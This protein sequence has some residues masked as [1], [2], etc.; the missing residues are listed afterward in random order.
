MT[1]FVLVFVSHS[2]GGHHVWQEC[3]QVST[4]A[5]KYMLTFPKDRYRQFS[6][7]L[8]KIREKCDEEVDFQHGYDS[9]L[10]EFYA[11]PDVVEQ[12]M[13]QNHTV[14]QFYDVLKTLAPRYMDLVNKYY[15]LNIEQEQVDDRWKSDP[16]YWTDPLVTPLPNVTKLKIYCSMIQR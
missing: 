7:K 12:I 9:I 8:K 13:T 4:E 3:S 15:H 14:E 1:C 5:S 10:E 11:N 2:Q 16:R 6:K